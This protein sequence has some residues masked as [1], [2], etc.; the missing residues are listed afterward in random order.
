M[1]E[2]LLFVHVHVIVNE[3][4][5]FLDHHS[6]HISSTI[7]SN[8]VTSDLVTLMNTYLNPTLS[9]LLQNIASGHLVSIIVVVFVVFA[10]VK[11]IQK[12]FC[13]YINT[14]DINTKIDVV[15]IE[16]NTVQKSR[17]E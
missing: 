10:F 1:F 7:L 4:G 9:L 2:G 17:L 15:K 6:F 8:E 12:R 14:V 5:F 3:F 13:F 11:L 16:D